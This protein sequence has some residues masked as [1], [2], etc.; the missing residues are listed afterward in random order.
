VEFRHINAEAELPF[1]RGDFDVII[2]SEVL[3]H[4][5]E[6]RRIVENIHAITTPD[7]R[8]VFTVPNE[9]PRLLAKKVLGAV[10]LMKVLFPGVEEGPSE[11]HLHCFSKKTLKDLVSDLFVIQRLRNVW[12]CHYVALLARRPGGA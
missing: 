10:G 1:E 9:R 3:E 12:S 7:T 8:V 11:W 5:P 2:C 4:T 6:P